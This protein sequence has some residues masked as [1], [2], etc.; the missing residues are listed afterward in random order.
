MA[1][2]S[3]LANKLVNALT[4]NEMKVKDRQQIL[5]RSLKLLFTLPKYQNE[6]EG[7]ELSMVKDYDQ[8]LKDI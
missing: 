6:F 7:L 5:I 8:I 4:V 2:N 1:V 3:E